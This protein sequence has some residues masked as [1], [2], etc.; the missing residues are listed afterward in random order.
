MN[1]SVYHS[2]LELSKMKFCFKHRHTNSTFTHIEYTAISEQ[3]VYTLL[4][5]LYVCIYSNDL[6][7]IIR[8]LIIFGMCTKKKKKKMMKRRRR[9]KK[10]LLITVFS[11][12]GQWCDRV[13]FLFASTFFSKSEYNMNEQVHISIRIC[14]FVILSVCVCFIEYSTKQKRKPCNKNNNNKK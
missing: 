4:I 9:Q 13:N 6:S 7:L 12:D 8:E 14:L 3:C 2:K 10:I 11:S 1:W 5:R